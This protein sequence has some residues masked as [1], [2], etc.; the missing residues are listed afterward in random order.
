M[1][2]VRFKDKK[3]LEK[4]PLVRWCP[5]PGCESYM[6]A[7]TS[8][9]AKITCLT[10]STEVCFKCRDVWHGENVSCDQHMQK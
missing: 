9:T 1:K 3:E 10:C 7:E 5:K 4:D 6:R 2:Y 8:D